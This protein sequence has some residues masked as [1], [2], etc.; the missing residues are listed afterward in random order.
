MWGK[1]LLA[2]H[3]NRT[4]RDSVYVDLQMQRLMDPF[5]D[6]MG[7]VYQHPPNRPNDRESM[8]FVPMSALMRFEDLAR[9]PA[10]DGAIGEKSRREAQVA[11]G[12]EQRG[13]SEGR[14][15]RAPVVRSIDPQADFVDGDGQPWDVKGF[16]SYPK[17]GEGGRYTREHSLKKIG[18]KL[19]KGFNVVLDTANLSPSDLADLK[20]AVEGLNVGPRVVFYP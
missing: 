6:N 5:H 7:R 3:D 20:I 17:P 13:D 12:M 14:K 15:V 16:H 10:H 9:D 8:V 11:L 4:G 2:V 18:Q 19:R 1:Q